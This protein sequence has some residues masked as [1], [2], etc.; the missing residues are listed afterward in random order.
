[1]AIGY[2]VQ[3]SVPRFFLL[4]VSYP[5]RETDS[6]RDDFISV[7]FSFITLH[8]SIYEMI[9]HQWATT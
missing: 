2:P 6:M 9:T 8:S 5:E 4:F 3:L 7:C 1:M